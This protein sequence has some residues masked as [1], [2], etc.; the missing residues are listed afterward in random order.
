MYFLNS[1]ATFS[2]GSAP[3]ITCRICDRISRIS[4]EDDKVRHLALIDVP[5]S[6]QR[7]VRHRASAIASSC[8]RPRRQ[9][10]QPEGRRRELEPAARERERDAGL[11]HARRLV[12]MR[13]TVLRGGSDRMLER[14]TGRRADRGIRFPSRQFSCCHVLSI[15]PRD[16]VWMFCSV[17]AVTQNA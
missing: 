15:S 12:G 16:S 1:T 14:M 17:V 6:C 9:L 5:T 7:R 10:V 13:G 11:Q 2:E 3:A 8:D 4:R